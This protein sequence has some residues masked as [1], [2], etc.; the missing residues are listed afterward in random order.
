M[1]RSATTSCLLTQTLWSLVEWSHTLSVLHAALLLHNPSSIPFHPSLCMGSRET[2]CFSVWGFCHLFIIAYCQNVVS[3]LYHLP[4]ACL[5]LEFLLKDK[6]RTVFL[7]LFVIGEARGFIWHVHGLWRHRDSS[8]EGESFWTEEGH[9]PLCLKDSPIFSQGLGGVLLRLNRWIRG[10]IQSGFPNST[11]PTECLCPAHHHKPHITFILHLKIHNTI[12]YWKSQLTARLS[13]P[14]LMPSLGRQTH[15][16]LS[17]CF[18]CMQYVEPAPFLSRISC[19]QGKDS[20]KVTQG[21]RGGGNGGRILTFLFSMRDS[22]SC[23]RLSSC[24]IPILWAARKAAAS[25]SIN[26]SGSFTN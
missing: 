21:A 10:P 20:F 7:S 17:P 26:H 2:L 12:F 19:F 24:L 16:H 22:G 15:Q 5:P 13:C 25:Q 18:G 6:S 14:Q 9:P 23:D 1:H 8:E 4:F 3:P 11:L